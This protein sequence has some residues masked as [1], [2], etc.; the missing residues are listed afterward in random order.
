MQR[1]MKIR[2]LFRQIFGVEMLVDVD[3]G[4]KKKVVRVGGFREEELTVCTVK[5]GVNDFLDYIS[6]AITLVLPFV[7]G[8][9]A[10]LPVHIYRIVKSVQEKFISD[11]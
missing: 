3:T 2:Q 6:L 11:T 8:P 4:L 1:S 5:T 10:S 7:F 9:V